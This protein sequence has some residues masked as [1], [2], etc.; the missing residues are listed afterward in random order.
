[1]KRYIFVEVLAGCMR[2]L[3]AWI[4]DNREFTAL[5]R[6]VIGIM[7]LWADTSIL[8]FGKS[9]TTTTNNFP[10]VSYGCET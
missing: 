4:S 6:P 1:M 5:G 10:F 3:D 2:I 8:H 9:T 7:F